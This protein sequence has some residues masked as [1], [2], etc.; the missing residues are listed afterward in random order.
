MIFSAVLRDISGSPN[1]LFSKF[2]VLQ[3]TYDIS[4]KLRIIL[5]LVIKYLN[6]MKFL[7]AWFKRFS[8][9]SLPFVH[10]TLLVYNQKDHNKN[11]TT[12]VPLYWICDA[13]KYS[14]KILL[15]YSSRNRLILYKL[16]KKWIHIHCMKKLNKKV[17]LWK[18]FFWQL[19]IHMIKVGVAQLAM[20]ILDSGGA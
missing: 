9:H 2:A 11:T 6:T 12:M 16:K 3:I 7:H 14:S 17:I 13:L 18:R 20:V 19:Y 10:S 5:W 15:Y 1:L 4:G 8:I